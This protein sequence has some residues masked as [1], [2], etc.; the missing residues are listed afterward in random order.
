MKKIVFLMYTHVSL[1]KKLSNP[2][3]A[4]SQLQAQHPDIAGRIISMALESVDYSEERACQILKIVM[5]DETKPTV[6]QSTTDGVVKKTV[7]Q[8]SIRYTCYFD[9][10]FLI[11]DVYMHDLCLT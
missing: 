3:A 6:G 10:F 7:K 2:F 8:P 11:G 4:K 1:K 5:Q 9:C